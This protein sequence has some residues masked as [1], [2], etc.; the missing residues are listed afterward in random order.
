MAI[1]LESALIPSKTGVAVAIAATEAAVV[2]VEDMAGAMAEVVA[3]V[4]TVSE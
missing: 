1:G 2:V 4:A 3:A